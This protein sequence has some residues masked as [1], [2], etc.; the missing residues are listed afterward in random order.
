[1]GKKLLKIEIMAKSSR[2]PVIKEG[3]A[4]GLNGLNKEE[5]KLHFARHM[6]LPFPFRVLFSPVYSP[7]RLIHDCLWMN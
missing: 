3:F 2:R 5:E 4:E 7:L 6:L 1:L